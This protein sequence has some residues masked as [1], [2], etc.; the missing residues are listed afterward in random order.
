VR[1]S[2]EDGDLFIRRTMI[3]GKTPLYFLMATGSSDPIPLQTLD[4]EEIRRAA[5]ATEWR[6]VGDPRR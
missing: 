6:Y 4:I 2:R 5:A 3:G 1:F